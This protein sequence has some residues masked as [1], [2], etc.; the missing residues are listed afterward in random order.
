[1]ARKATTKTPGATKPKPRRTAPGKTKLM[2]AGSAPTPDVKRKKNIFRTGTVAAVLLLIIMIELT[3]YLKGEKEKTNAAELTPVSTPS[4]IFSVNDGVVSSIEI[5]PAT[6]DGVKLA[7][8]AESA[9]VVEMPIKAEADQGLAESAA[10]QV[11]SLSVIS[12]IDADPEIFGLK[13]PPFVITLEFSG[14]KKHTLEIGDVTPSKSGFYV[15]VD[16]DKM[17][18][19]DLSGIQA[20]LQ[21][22]SVPP[23]LNTPM[24]SPTLTPVPATEAPQVSTP[25][26]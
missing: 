16:K 5:K 24:P 11:F 3:V 6:G 26:P 13:N 8:N 23:Y 2:V 25:T 12:Q 22:V 17:M 14:G 15:R 18:I 7:R 9:W 1:M 20:L 10:T 19:A 4:H 21:L